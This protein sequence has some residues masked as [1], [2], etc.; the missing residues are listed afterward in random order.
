[1]REGAYWEPRGEPLQENGH[2]FQVRQVHQT[3]EEEE[4]ESGGN[5][6]GK[7]RKAA[8]KRGGGGRVVWGGLLKQGPKE[9][10]KED[11]DGEERRE[12]WKN[13]VREWEKEGETGSRQEAA[14]EDE[15]MCRE[16]SPGTG[17]RWGGDPGRR[18]LRAR[19]GG[20]R[21]SKARPPLTFE[22][23]GVDVPVDAQEVALPPE[24]GVGGEERPAALGV[25]PPEP[26]QRAPGLGVRVP[27]AA[28]EQ[29]APERGRVPERQVR[30]R[31][32]AVLL[33]R[34]VG[35]GA[36]ELAALLV[37]PGVRLVPVVGEDG[38]DQQ[39]QG[40]E[41]EAEAERRDERPRLHGSPPRRSPAAAGGLARR[42]Q[43]QCTWP[44]LSSALP[45][46]ASP[47]T[48]LLAPRSPSS[49]SYL[50]S[51]PPSCPL[52]GP[53]SS[54]PPPFL[55]APCRADRTF[56]PSS[57]SPSAHSLRPPRAHAPRPSPLLLIE[58]SALLSSDPP[59]LLNA[60]SPPSLF[61]LTSSSPR[62]Y[63]G[64]HFP[65]TFLQL[66]PSSLLPC[67]PLFTGSASLLVPALD[68]LSPLPASGALPS[69]DVKRYP[70]TSNSAL[71]L[72]PLDFDQ[73]PVLYPE[74]NPTQVALLGSI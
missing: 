58:L 52:P 3:G 24:A 13:Q 66:F 41:A 38:R 54:P 20:R 11:Q 26:Q 30:Q 65:L 1:M 59:S 5:S 60:S 43:T 21:G 39:P 35:A 42:R 36:A 12:F 23:E 64:S 29:P 53:E 6:E 16:R 47:P 19:A 45:P 72:V 61:S 56:S 25:R 55:P 57:S 73:R 22:D 2:A 50:S 51:P 27:G 15:R 32:Q 9:R 44:R 37:A 46:A 49:P 67:V 31:H 14:G 33:V 28:R 63:P 62:T 17:A 4:R 70:P 18:R 34:G 48:R 8:E 40:A 71:S 69:N 10:G 74:A 68:W 7:G